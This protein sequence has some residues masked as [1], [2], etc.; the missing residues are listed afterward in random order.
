MIFRETKLAGAFV[1][2]LEP[3]TDD[4]GFFARCFCEREFAE[5]GLPIRF[6]QCNVSRN[7]AKGTLRG[8]HF[9]AA[10]HQESK[11]VRCVTGAIHDV[12]VDLRAGSPTY[13]AWVGIDLSA[14]N[15]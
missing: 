7:K 8:M 12:V 2:D 6:P 14:E 3:R 1:I 10:P 15:G 13:L 5:H 11:L 9:Q 4:R